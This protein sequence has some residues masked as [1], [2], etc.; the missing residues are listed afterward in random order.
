[1]QRTKE[2]ILNEIRERKEEFSKEEL[3]SVIKK[4][5]GESKPFA[6]RKAIAGVSYGIGALIVITGVLLLLLQYW[7]DIGSTLRVMFTFGL[8]IAVFLLTLFLE[9]RSQGMHVL[10]DALSVIAASLVGVGGFVFVREV[11]D[12][13]ITPGVFLSVSLLLTFMFAGLFFIRRSSFYLFFV[14]ASLTYV[15]YSFISLNVIQE[16]L[17]RTVDEPR[18]FYAYLTSLI[19]ILYALFAYY[20]PRPKLSTLLYLLG[21]VMLTVPF[22]FL[23]EIYSSNLYYVICALLVFVVGMAGNFLQRVVFSFAGG[24]ALVAG[25]VFSLM[26]AFLV[27]GILFIAA[28]LLFFIAK[29][30]VRS[31]SLLVAVGALTWI[32]YLIFSTEFFLDRFAARENPETFFFALTSVLGIS[33]IFLGKLF[34]QRKLSGVLYFLGSFSLVVPFFWFGEMYGGLWDLFS[35]LLVLIIIS[36]GVYLQRKILVI[37]G[38]VLLAG[39]IVNVSVRHFADTVGWPITLI[40]AGFLL[41]G[42]GYLSY[43]LSRK[44]GKDRY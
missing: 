36:L 18:S 17:H 33:Y 25:V 4:E 40:V 42:A 3:L 13:D 44:A 41:M 8:G 7:G 6:G 12:L 15:F 11:A 43:L 38:G 30:D 20:F 5:S 26:G 39:V 23:G 32:P 1:M 16:G 14:I 35:A 10:R 34:S 19:G 29:R 24:V 31:A 37:C 28:A 27:T 22:I 21:S 2:E 9:I